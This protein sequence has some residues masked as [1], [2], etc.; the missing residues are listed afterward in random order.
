MLFER[1]IAIR[2]DPVYIFPICFC[3]VV[4]NVFCPFRLTLVT[5]GVGFRWLVPMS[6]ITVSNNRI[7]VSFVLCILENVWC[8][9]RSHK[10]CR[11]VG[12]NVSCIYVMV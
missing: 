5:F 7:E 10:A 8:V 4:G 3:W 6:V 1:R 9:I 11:Y 12:T 2:I